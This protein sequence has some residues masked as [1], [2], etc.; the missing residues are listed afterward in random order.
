VRTSLLTLHAPNL[1]T[2]SYLGHAA[3]PGGKAD[4]LDE[5]PCISPHILI[6]P[7]RKTF[8]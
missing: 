1:L 3:L 8:P 2:N 7:I 6:I 5:T 4:T